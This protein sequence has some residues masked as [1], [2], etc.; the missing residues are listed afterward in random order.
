MEANL[1]RKLAERAITKKQLLE[2]IGS[3]FALLPVVIGGISS[4]KA[5]VRYGCASIL[6]SLSAKAPDKLYSNMDFFVSLLDSERRILVWNAMAVVANL[7]AVDVDKK[8]DTIF[9][10]Y[11]AFLNDNYL[12]TVAN[13][14]SNSK[15]IALAKPYL[16]PRITAELL[17]VDKISTSPH[18]TDECR[19]VV[20]EQAIKFFNLFFDKMGAEDRA[21]VLL[22]VKKQADSSRA[23]LAKEAKLFLKQRSS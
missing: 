7:C 3:D 17:L 23:S 21:K 15:K 4:S 20:A 1:L 11:Y 5:T 9:D 14:V 16:I 6:V 19:R 8:F 12:V 18:L 10:K 13:V 22:F 2:T